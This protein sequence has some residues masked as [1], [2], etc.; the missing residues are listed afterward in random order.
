MAYC[1]IAPA[2]DSDNQQ[3]YAGIHPRYK[4]ATIGLSGR[5]TWIIIGSVQESILGMKG[6][7]SACPVA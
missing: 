5:L 3:Q 4:G 7:Q 6:P 1:Q 2:L